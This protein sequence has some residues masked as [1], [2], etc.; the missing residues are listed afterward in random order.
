MQNSRPWQQDSAA[1]I[2]RCRASYGHSAYTAQ[3]SRVTP[4][5]SLSLEEL[6]KKGG[7]GVKVAQCSGWAGRDWQARRLA[8]AE[9]QCRHQR[10][11]PKTHAIDASKSAPTAPQPTA[12]QQTTSNPASVA[13][14]PRKTRH[15]CTRVRRPAALRRFH[16]LSSALCVI[17]PSISPLLTYSPTR[18]PLSRYDIRIQHP[19]T[20]TSE[21]RLLCC[22]P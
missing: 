6:A 17:G 13:T 5:G 19:A 1:D 8:E 9:G 3:H 20:P 10:S 14:R 12:T 22:G 21:W 11:P 15:S 18:Q 16:R 2:P 4:A 7:G